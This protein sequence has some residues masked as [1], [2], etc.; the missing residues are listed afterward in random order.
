MLSCVIRLVA[1]A[2]II[3]GSLLSVVYG[4]FVG[5]C[6]CLEGTFLGRCLLI[7]LLFVFVLEIVFVFMFV[8][9]F[10]FVFA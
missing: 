2:S 1:S 7:E 10:V 5:C 4:L 9:V 3:V 6:C 8:F